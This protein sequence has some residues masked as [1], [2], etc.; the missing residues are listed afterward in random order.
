[1]FPLQDAKDVEYLHAMDIFVLFVTKSANSLHATLDRQLQMC[2]CRESAFYAAHQDR[3]N[4]VRWSQMASRDHEIQL[5]NMASETSRMQ[6]Q[7]LQHFLGLPIDYLDFR[8][9]H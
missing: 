4:L 1:M 9:Y 3:Y 6:P 2:C 5:V 8:L 7:P